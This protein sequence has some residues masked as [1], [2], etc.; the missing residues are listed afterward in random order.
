MADFLSPGKHVYAVHVPG[1][2]EKSRKPR[3]FLHKTLVSRREEE[4]PVEER[5]F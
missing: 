5:V 2:S 1:D 4:V 3:W